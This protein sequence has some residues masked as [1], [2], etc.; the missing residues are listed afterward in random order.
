MYPV[1]CTFVIERHNKSSVMYKYLDFI[2]FEKHVGFE[3]VDSFVYNI[4]ISS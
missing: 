2:A 3:K 4:V 1:T